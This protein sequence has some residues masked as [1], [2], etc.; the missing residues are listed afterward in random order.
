MEILDL[1]YNSI[2]F[3]ENDW[4]KS[5]ANTI[6]LIFLDNNRLN[7]MSVGLNQIFSSLSSLEDLSLMSNR[8]KFIPNVNFGL[9]RLNC[10]KNEITDIKSFTGLPDTLLELDLSSNL[11]SQIKHDSFSKFKKLASLNMENNRISVLEKNAFNQ[12][13]MLKK[14]NLKKNYLKS[15]PTDNIYNL[16]SLRH[17]DLSFQDYPGVKLNVIDDYAFD[18]NQTLAKELGI[19]SLDYTS[20]NLRGNPVTFFGKR[21]FCSHNSNSNWINIENLDLQE[22]NVN[23]LNPCLMKQ[24]SHHQNSSSKIKFNANADVKLNCNCEIFEYLKNNQVF[25]NGSCDNDNEIALIDQQQVCNTNITISCKRI[26]EY[27][28]EEKYNE[29]NA[30]KFW[31]S[32]KEF[33]HQ[34]N[35]T[36]SFSRANSFEIFNF[37][38]TTFTLIFCYFQ[39]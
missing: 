30:N 38:L 13:F 34:S 23:N 33:I 35:E 26:K 10:A 19:N 12:L 6:K 4:L 11:I 32:G 37:Y 15:L 2:Q 24:I 1:K 20:I 22:T 29:K 18:R 5:C 27:D 14:L 39:N 8:L 25:L 16:V 9:K 36:F 7:E 21:A 3:I 28:C 31:Y 17:I